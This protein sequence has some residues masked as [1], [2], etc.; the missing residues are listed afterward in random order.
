V[1]QGWVW[2]RKNIGTAIAISGK[3]ANGKAS[4]IEMMAKKKYDLG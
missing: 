1:C 2:G 4:K 3:N